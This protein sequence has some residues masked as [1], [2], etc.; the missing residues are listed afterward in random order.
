MHIMG[1]ELCISDS[2]LI[3]A[4]VEEKGNGGDLGL[5]KR[6]IDTEVEEENEDVEEEEE[7]E[8]DENDSANKKLNKEDFIGEIEGRDKYI[9]EGTD[10]DFENED[11]MNAPTENIGKSFSPA[12]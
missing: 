6:K 4:E 11:D 2:A 7:D 10:S 9:G 3:K 8:D 1:S 12:M 5:R